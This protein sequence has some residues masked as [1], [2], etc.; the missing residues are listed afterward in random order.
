VQLRGWMRAVNRGSAWKTGADPPNAPTRAAG[1]EIALALAYGTVL[2]IT[3][4]RL[5]LSPVATT[6]RL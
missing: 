5:A 6:K 4:V 2:K 1:R 3:F